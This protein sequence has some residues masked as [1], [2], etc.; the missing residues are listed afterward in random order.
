MEE[1]FFSVTSNYYGA[2]ARDARLAVLQAKLEIKIIKKIKED[3][4]NIFLNCAHTVSD[5]DTTRV[6]NIGQ[7][8][9][10]GYN[11]ILSFISRAKK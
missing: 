7:I 4:C 2:L 6:D 9:K 5:G 3:I 11:K 10:I 8:A 1:D